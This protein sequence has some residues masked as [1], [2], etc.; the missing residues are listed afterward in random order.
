MVKPLGEKSVFSCPDCGGVMWS[1][2]NMPHIKQYR[3][4]IGQA[5]SEDDLVI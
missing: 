3:C 4:H 1:V 5:Y 2:D